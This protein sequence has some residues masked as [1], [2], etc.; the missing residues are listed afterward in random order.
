MEFVRK[1]LSLVLRVLISGAVLTGLAFKIN[2]REFWAIVT[3]AHVGW[4]GLGLLLIGLN[5]LGSTYRWKVLLRIQGI[6]L[7]YRRL[8][9]MNMIGQFFNAFLLGVTGGDVMKIY[10]VT[11]ATP[12][13]RS[14]AGLSVIYDR[15]LGLLGIM[16]WGLVL[17][18]IYYR[19]LTS[20][21]NTHKSVWTFIL[22]CG[23]AVGGISAALVLPW[24]RKNSG[25][26]K[27]EQKLPFHRTLENLSEAFQRYAESPAENLL[28]FGFSIL[29]HGCLFLVMYFVG[30]AID[31]N[32]TFWQLA[33]IVSVV[34]V[35]IAIPINVA[36]LGVRE[37]LFAIF[38]GLLGVPP[39]QAV[40]F[41]LLGFGLNLIWSLAGG[42][43]YMRY[44]K[45]D[46]PANPGVPA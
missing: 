7:P 13:K 12:E 28:V 6:V 15:V 11:Q 32:V 34:N 8:F 33:A 45:H 9:P 36:G 19:F 24:I 2:W 42:I 14:A 30:L 27:L 44:K 10:Y 38:L 31:L 4:L 17:T 40:A 46:H 21:P 37:G 5:M 39:S 16:A 22:I 26:W 1:H 23:V 18:S 41:S 35:L 43:Y 29:L 20:T 25:L 3:N